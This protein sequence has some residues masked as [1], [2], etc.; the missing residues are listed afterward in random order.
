MRTLPLLFGA[1]LVAACASSG[2]PPAATGASSSP[3]AIAAA[4][5][6]PDRSSEDRA[7]DAGRH[8]AELLG[9][10]RVAPGQKVAE[11][12]AGGGYTTELLA[13]VVGPGG[14]VYAENNRLVLERFAAKPWGERLAKP[15]MANV[16]RVDRE[17]DDPLP[18]E[19]R[20]LD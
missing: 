11:L 19:A 6:A 2:A 7:L 3:D 14:R 4:V 18:P 12:L 5:A 16:V 1:C 13:R 17:L 20:D 15:V 8:P 9:L 10:A